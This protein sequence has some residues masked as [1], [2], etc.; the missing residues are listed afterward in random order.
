VLVHLLVLDL[1]WRQLER[2]QPRGDHQSRQGEPGALGTHEA[3]PR[4]LDE[5]ARHRGGRG[6][7]TTAQHEGRASA[8]EPGELEQ[9]AQHARFVGRELHADGRSERGSAA[10]AGDIGGGESGL[11]GRH[12]ASLAYN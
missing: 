4:Q 12:A 10:R 6:V 7:Q 11:L 3:A 2:R 9:G 8:I 5:R 1:G